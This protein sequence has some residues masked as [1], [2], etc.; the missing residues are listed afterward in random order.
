M[1]TITTFLF[2]EILFIVLNKLFLKTNELRLTLF[3]AVKIRMD[4]PAGQPNNNQ[5]DTNAPTNINLVNNNLIPDE[6]WDIYKYELLKM[7]KFVNGAYSNLQFVV[8]IMIFIYSCTKADHKYDFE[9]ISAFTIY[10][11]FIAL[12]SI[13][14]LVAFLLVLWA[15]LLIFMKRSNLFLIKLATFLSAAQSGFSIFYYVIFTEYMF[16]SKEKDF[17][18]VG[19]MIF[20][21]ILNIGKKDYMTVTMKD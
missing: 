5:T 9:P 6:L 3:Q 11:Y 2:G 4:L 16:M 10:T 1:S 8:M 19:Y 14:L 18:M 13:M 7:A 12:I 17:I 15:I 20:N 21:I